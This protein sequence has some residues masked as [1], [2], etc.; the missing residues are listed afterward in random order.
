MV[1]K[2]RVRGRCALARWPFWTNRSVMRSCCGRSMPRCSCHWEAGKVPI[3]EISFHGAIGIEHTLDDD[4]NGEITA[5]LAETTRFVED[6]FQRAHHREAIIGAS[7]ALKEALRQVEV[8]AP[9]DAT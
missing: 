8:V 4:H 2:R 5:M 1:T 3:V 9:T 7:P 6:R